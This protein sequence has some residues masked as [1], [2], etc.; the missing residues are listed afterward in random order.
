MTILRIRNLSVEYADGTWALRNVSLSIETG[1]RVAI[2]GESG[3]GKSTLI[4]ALLR[5]LPP[6]AKVTGHA[7]IDGKHQISAMT[8]RE[9]RQLRGQGQRLAETRVLG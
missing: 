5:L 8:E 6:A 7:V 3:C 9:M 1:E 2:L 4:K